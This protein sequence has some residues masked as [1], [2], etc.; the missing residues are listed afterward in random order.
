MIRRLLWVVSLAA[1]QVSASPLGTVPRGCT[2]SV[3]LGTFQI[4]V[5]RSP[6][7][8]PL[9][10]KSVARVPAGAR[11]IWNPVHLSPAVSQSG[12]VAAL[13]VPQGRDS[14]TALEA[15]RAAYR[16]EWELPQ[17]PGVVAFIVGPHGLSMSKVKS[18]VARN[19]DLLTQLADY[20]Q[21]TSEVETLVQE[22]ADA[23]TTG[24][25]TDAALKGFSSQFGVAMPKLD[26]KAATDQQASVL[27]HAVL[28]SASAYDPLASAPAQ[29]AQ[30]V[31]LAASVAGLFFGNGVT[32]AA[33]GTALFTN[34][35]AV[36]FP[37]MEFRSA[38]AQA[39]EGT[40]LAL[41][42]KSTEAKTRTRIAYLWA[43]RVP[44]LNPPVVA[45]AGAEHLP[46]GA[47]S[48]LPLKASEGS[49]VK[50]LARAH[51]WRLIP[52]DGGTPVAP[53]VTLADTN[54]VE[55]DLTKCK[56][57]P[58]EYRLAAEWDWD[59]IS[60]GTVH[61]N[62]L[63]DFSA[64]K[65]APGS[66]DKLVE[67]S[68]MVTATLSGADFE[69]VEKVQ[70]KKA[71]KHAKPT[72]VAF[73]LPTGK[74]AGEQHTLEVTLD[75]AARGSYELLLQQSDGKPHE[76][77]VTVLPPNPKISALPARINV[78]EPRQHVRFAG[79]G[80]DRVDS[81]TTPAGALTGTGAAAEWTG[82]IQLAAGLHVG[83]RLPLLLHVKGLD[84]PLTLPD[85]IEVVGPRPK[86]GAL[87]KSLPANLGVD[88]RQEELPAGIT[89]GLV[90]PVKDL[91]GRPQVELGCAHD[92]LRKA[93]TLTPDE[94]AGGASLS[95][96]GPGELYLSFDPGAV[97]YPGCSISA[98]VSTQPEGRS[99][100][101]PLGTVVRLP[102][103]DRFTLTSES[104]GPSSFAG[105]LK[106]TDLDLVE[107]VG[108]DAD[109]GLPVQA[110]PTPIPGEP[111]RQTLRVSLP[112]P[113]PAPHAPLYIWLRGESQGRKTVVAD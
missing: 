21:Q 91:H 43:Y 81:L 51:D 90:M 32:L 1:A 88:L 93:L 10:L 5:R 46:L 96:A 56:A 65:L 89:L 41:C 47:R 11:L 84:D 68:G 30:S 58:G 108:W 95:F 99:D 107:K 31:G 106:G 77:P 38:F 71:G 97:G 33:G 80:L 52:I 6:S 66:R 54:S 50:D 40:S 79:D 25:G 83:Q 48:P 62:P 109:H 101:A 53:T 94:P 105:I 26:T 19:E 70:C 13:I 9:P 110:I 69:F 74:R 76:V 20:A 37:G 78:D 64:V 34:L 2:G 7:A 85:A 82:D 24:G 87:R 16:T 57:A 12:E 92:G 18:L 104:T 22:L 112:W 75:T 45:I 61:L 36:M 111:S 113:A 23:E 17:T 72:D 15:R 86:I 27:L 100:P 73:E 63:A 67:G 29:M 103:L 60:L 8:P 42:T 49:S 44:N 28:P 14:V 35:K 4:T 39:N 59:P 102:H 98:I 55:L 3:S